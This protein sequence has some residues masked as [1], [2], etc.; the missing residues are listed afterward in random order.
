[1]A[2]PATPINKIVNALKCGNAVIVAP[3]PKGYSSCALL[4][5]F[6]HAQLRAARAAG[7]AIL[8]I[9]ADL[10][11]VLALSD[12]IAVMYEGKFAT[13]LPRAQASESVL[14]PFMTGAAT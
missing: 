10:T 14:G 1:M 3:S 6:I 11:E 12:R 5:E 7:K 9:S 8:L 2:A 13:V 4:I